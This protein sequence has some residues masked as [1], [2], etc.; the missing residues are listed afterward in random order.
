[1]LELLSEVSLGT[2][3]D[4]IYWGSESS[5]RYASRSLYRM[6][7]FKGVREQ[8]VEEIWKMRIPLKV[9]IFIWMAVHD[10]IQCGVQLRKQ[11]WT[12]Q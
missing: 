2:E 3:R 11:N 9:Q 1:M 8:Q 4:E 7:T 12:G 5:G 6:V 10:Q